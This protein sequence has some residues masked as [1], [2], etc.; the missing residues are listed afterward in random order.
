MNL[1]DEDVFARELR[2]AVQGVPLFGPGPQLGSIRRRGAARR[3]RHQAAAAG[4]VAA[5]LALAG[6]LTMTVNND[7][8][9]GPG[10]DFARGGSETAPLT[11]TS[12][13]AAVTEI[14]N[15]ALDEAGIAYPP[16]PRDHGDGIVTPGE[17][18]DTGQKLV[19]TKSWSIT[20]SQPKIAISLHVYP[21]SWVP[22]EAYPCRQGAADQVR[23]CRDE[24]LSNGIRL[25]SG[26]DSGGGLING[27]DRWSMWSPAALAVYPDGRQVS[28]SVGLL[29]EEGD[30]VPAGVVIEDYRGPITLDQLRAAVTSPEL[31]RVGLPQ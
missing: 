12:D 9:N 10:S 1:V 14:I 5:V 13:P 24:V 6:T 17:D 28:M 18:G 27:N 11:Q 21:E 7:T 22:E 4:S 16:E 8:L 2:E 26:E 30:S 29:K 15:R 3:R 20:T 19:W 23:S 31:A 25:L